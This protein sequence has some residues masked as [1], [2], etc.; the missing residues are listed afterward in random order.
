MY[1]HFFFHESNTYTA[2]MSCRLG[3][4]AGGF[5]DSGVKKLRGWLSAF[6]CESSFTKFSLSIQF[7]I[8][9]SLFSLSP[10][11]FE[12]IIEGGTS[13]S[14]P[15]NF[16]REWFSSLTD[17]QRSFLGIHQTTGENSC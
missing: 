15:A 11:K 6:V 14:I 1:Y 2:M 7:A 8:I 9:N 17:V 10:I 4:D 13:H 5:D 16:I 3:V 12:D